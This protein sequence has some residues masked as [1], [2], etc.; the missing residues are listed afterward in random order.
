MRSPK[1]LVI[2]VEDQSRKDLPLVFRLQLRLDKI[3][4]SHYKKQ[5]EKIPELAYKLTD[6]Y[7]WLADQLVKYTEKLST[8]ILEDIKKDKNISQRRLKKVIMFQAALVSIVVN[9]QGKEIDRAQRVLNDF[10][11][12]IMKYSSL[13]KEMVEEVS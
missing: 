9:Q 8:S 2:K 12:S 3:R 11:P 4:L 6:P 13:P 5:A 1:S 10:F 7:G